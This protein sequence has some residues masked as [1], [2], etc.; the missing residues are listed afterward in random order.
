MSE[1]R[2]SGQNLP[3]DYFG[4]MRG[5]H[6]SGLDAGL[7]SRVDAL[8][9]SLPLEMQSAIRQLARAGFAER[10]AVLAKLDKKTAS[11]MRTIIAC[12]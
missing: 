9:L 10:E 6:A 7:K 8:M 11:A 3:S 2:S 1:C 4:S 12:L 5:L